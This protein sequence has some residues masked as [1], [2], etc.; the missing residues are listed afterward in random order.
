VTDQSAS[1]LAAF[2]GDQLAKAGWAKQDSGQ[3]GAVAWSTWL[4]RDK[5]GK[6]WRGMFFAL[7]L[8]GTPPQRFVYVR[9]DL[10]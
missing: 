10:Q 3:S 4:V 7:D 6:N 5:D 9:V 8:P 2:Y 1:T